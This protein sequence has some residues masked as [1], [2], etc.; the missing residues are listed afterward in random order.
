M[1]EINQVN[2]WIIFWWGILAGW[3]CI[4]GMR[5]AVEGDWEGA[6]LRLLFIVIITFYVRRI[7][8]IDDEGAE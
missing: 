5:D 1:S 3:N 8:S 7:K 6:V 2:K 4:E